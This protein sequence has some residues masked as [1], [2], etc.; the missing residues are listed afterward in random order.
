MGF[1]DTNDEAY[2]I[3]V[4]QDPAFPAGATTWC[5]QFVVFAGITHDL[6]VIKYYDANANGQYDGTPFVDGEPLLEGWQIRIQDGIDWI[7][8]TPVNISLPPDIYTVT[9]LMPLEPNW[10]CTTLNPVVVDLTMQNRIVK[11]GNVCVGSGG[12]RTP[13]FWSN[14]NGRALIRPEDLGFLAGLNLRELNGD[15]FD[16]TRYSDLRTWLLNANATNMACMLSVH[17]ASMNLNVIHGFV[18]EDA[19]I[20][21]EGTGLENGYGFATVRAVLDQA[22]FMLGLHGTAD[23]QDPWRAEMEALKTALSTANNNTGFFQPIPCPY[24][25][26]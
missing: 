25:F 20:Y 13:G 26:Q 3:W 15:N 6:R 5:D 8:G 18:D 7:R 21:A 10:I 14:K 19:L 22:N 12:G 23:P 17:T 2:K 4:S 11:F 16:P 24:T 1:D 9:E